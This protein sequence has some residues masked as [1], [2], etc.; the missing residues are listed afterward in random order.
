MV[1]ICDPWMDKNALKDAKKIKKKIFALC[2][3]NNYTFDINF[4]IPCNNKSSKGIGLIFYILTREYLKARKI[5]KQVK[6]EDFVE[7]E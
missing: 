4:V 7:L 1:F 2:D 5:K 3:T 6:M